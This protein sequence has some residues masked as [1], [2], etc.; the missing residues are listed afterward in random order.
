MATWPVSALYEPTTDSLDRSH[1]ANLDW[2]ADSQGL[3][4]KY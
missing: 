2:I 4:V 3:V 1:G